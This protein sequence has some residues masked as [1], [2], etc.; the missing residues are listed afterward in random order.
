VLVLDG[1]R[2]VPVWRGGG[3]GWFIRQRASVVARGPFFGD[4]PRGWFGRV[5]SVRPSAGASGRLAR[6]AELSGRAQ[7]QNLAASSSMDHYI[8]RELQGKAP[9]TPGGP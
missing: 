1:G 9:V 6:A 8:A 4:W 3:R 2:A 5:P 7:A